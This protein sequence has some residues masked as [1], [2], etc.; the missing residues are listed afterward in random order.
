MPLNEFSI[1]VFLISYHNMFS[2]FF[3]CLY[4]KTMGY[5]F[6]LTA[7]WHAIDLISN[8]QAYSIAFQ[9]LKK[10]YN[11]HVALCNSERFVVYS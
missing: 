10:L 7:N 5:V 1:E 3:V 2:R 9:H 4:F 11:P 6:L 8:G